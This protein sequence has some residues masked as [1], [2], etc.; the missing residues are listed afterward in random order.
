[1]SM[2]FSIHAGAKFKNLISGF[3]MYTG[4][5]T[6]VSNQRPNQ[7]CNTLG[8]DD[9]MPVGGGKQ[10]FSQFLAYRSHAGQVENDIHSISLGN[11]FI[12][13]EDIYPLSLSG[14]PTRGTA[15]FHD[16]GDRY[17]FTGRTKQDF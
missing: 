9:R 4:Q 12:N 15:I 7:A 11:Q 6:T 3:I 8:G 2:A 14:S 5:I 13:A 17:A 16:S 1:M 10:F